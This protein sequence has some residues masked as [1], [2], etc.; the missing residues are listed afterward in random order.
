MGIPA[1]GLNLLVSLSLGIVTALIARFGETTV[2]AYGVAHKIEAFCF[3]IYIA[4]G[5][6]LAPFAGQNWGAGHYRRVRRALSLSFRFAWL[7]GIALSVGMA[8]FGE[9]IMR[10]FS[11]DPQIVEAGRLFLCVVPVSFGAEG[12]IM[13]SSAVFNALGRPLTAITIVA[14]RMVIVFVPLALL[15]RSFFGYQGVFASIAL[16]N[17]IVCLGVYLWDRRF[18]K[19]AYRN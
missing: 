8:F 13:F 6:V 14:M 11:Q 9:S 15:G 1:T 5:S 18:F 3:H 4:L 16:T 7:L 19:E 2:A 17:F 10:V 12:V